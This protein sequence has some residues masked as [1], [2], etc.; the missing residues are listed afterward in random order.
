MATSY[1]CFIHL[2]RKMLY[3]GFSFFFFSYVLAL[4]PLLPMCVNLIIS[5]T[6]H[7]YSYTYDQESK[8]EYIIIEQ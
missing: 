7:F 2:K 5:N 1:T 3:A 4:P 8:N 6:A